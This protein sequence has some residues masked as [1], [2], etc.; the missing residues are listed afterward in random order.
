[1]GTI[2]YEP[3]GV[4]VGKLED[5]VWASVRGPSED[6]DRWFVEEEGGDDYL[7]EVSLSRSQRTSTPPGT[8]TIE[9][10][11]F[12]TEAEVKDAIRRAIQRALVSPTYKNIKPG[13]RHRIRVTCFDLYNAGGVIC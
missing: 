10:D 11:D 4:K 7:F 5:L 6:G 12:P 2:P 13:S 8:K 1:M 9:R 3:F